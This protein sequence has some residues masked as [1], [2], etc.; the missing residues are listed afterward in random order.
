MRVD[1]GRAGT[2]GQLHIYLKHALRDLRAYV[3]MLATC[4]GVVD[5]RVH[6]SEQ[7]EKDALAPRSIAACVCYKT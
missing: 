6:G 2:Q 5:L 1:T 7:V 3:C 4:P